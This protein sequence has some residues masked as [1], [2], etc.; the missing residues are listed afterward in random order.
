ML[1]SIDH[2]SRAQIHSNC[3][4]LLEQYYCK[5]LG[6]DP[7]KHSYDADIKQNPDTQKLY[8]QAEKR[9]SN[10]FDTIFG[11]TMTGINNIRMFFTDL[12]QYQPLK[13]RKAVAEYVKAIGL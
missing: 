2:I 11:I 8:W 4:R 7:K 12:R 1:Y 3:T 9:A 13:Y 5:I 6:L 10:T